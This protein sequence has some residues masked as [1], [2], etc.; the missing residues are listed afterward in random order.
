MSAD[1]TAARQSPEHRAE[2]NGVVSGPIGPGHRRFDD[3]HLQA[4]GRHTSRIV[5]HHVHDDRH[6]HEHRS[7]IDHLYRSG[8]RSADRQARRGS[9]SP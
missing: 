2:E 1:L 7:D 4:T 5:D 9:L 6:Y 3:G 8:S